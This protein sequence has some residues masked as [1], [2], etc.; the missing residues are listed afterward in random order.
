MLIVLD[1]MI[2]DMEA[3]KKICLIA[4]EFFL[5]ARNLK[6]FFIS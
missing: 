4:T 1:D 2:A 3:S 5:R 6:F